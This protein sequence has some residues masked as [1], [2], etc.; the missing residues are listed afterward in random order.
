MAAHRR[1]QAPDAERTQASGRQLAS[2]SGDIL[3]LLGI[4]PS[5]A[6]VLRYFA[7]HPDAD[8]HGRQLQR[9]LGV[10]SASLQRDLERLA[11]LGSLERVREARLVRYRPVAAS[12]LWQ[13]VQLLL[14]ESPDIAPLV[15]DALRTVP[16]VDSAF[17][18]GST[19]EGAAT[20]ESDIDL[21]VVEAPSLDRRA[22]NCQL[23]QLGL[24]LDRQ[25]NA[26]RYTPQSLG[27]RL[28]DPDHPAHRFTRAVL[29]GPKRWVAGS[30]HT[31]SAL[32]AAAGI[33]MPDAPAAAA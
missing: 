16:G 29:G 21:F 32:A 8:A 7:V 17:I 2:S 25:V 30:P 14:R 33:P 20:A 3:E 11:A 15:R 23:F 31:I 12:R 27:E 13:A 26:V 18:F 4:S 22:L 19:A 24:V 5:A 10:G 28:G 1:K 9:E 6:R